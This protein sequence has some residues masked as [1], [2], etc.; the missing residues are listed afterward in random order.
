MIPATGAPPIGG[1]A[2]LVFVAG[3]CVIEHRA[4]TLQVAEVVAEIAAQT[5]VPVIFKASFDKANRSHRDAFRGPGLHAGL[6]ILSEVKRQF[7]LPVLTDVHRPEQCAVAAEVVDV[8][9]VPAFLCR[10]TDLLQ[11]AGATGLPVNL[12]RGQFL[13]PRRMGLALEKIGPRAWLTERGTTFGHGDLI[14]DPR[15]LLWMR[16]TGAPVLYDAT[17]SVQSPSGVG[18]TTGGHR[19][20]ALPLARAAVAVGIDGL[21]AEVHLDPPN[22]KS[23]AAT[24]LTPAAFAELVRQA[25]RIDAAR[26]G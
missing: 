13:D 7:G 25:L 26:R 16:E 18:P 22:A 15:S 23:D 8:L 5:G 3:P 11:A 9:Q 14:F 19:G 21:F 4:Q 24:Q 1:G 2:P 10:Q 12:K 17:H 6:N 20:L